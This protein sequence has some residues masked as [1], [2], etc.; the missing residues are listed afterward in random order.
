MMARHLSSGT[1][2]GVGQEHEW[3]R[4]EAQEQEYEEDEEFIQNL[5]HGRILLWSTT[6]PLAQPSLAQRLRVACPHCYLQ[7]TFLQP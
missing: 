5:K 7:S 3:E 6:V 2:R 4:E 1:L